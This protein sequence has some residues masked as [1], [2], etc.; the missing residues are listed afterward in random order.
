[1]SRVMKRWMATLAAVALFGTIIAATPSQAAVPG[2][3]ERPKAVP[4]SQLPRDVKLWGAG[5]PVFGH[6]SVWASLNNIPPRSQRWERS[7]EGLYGLKFPWF[8]SP[9]VGDVPTITGRR[10][11]GPGTFSAKAN[12]AFDGT[13]WASSGLQFSA[14]GCWEVTGEYRGEELTFRVHV[15]A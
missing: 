2:G 3:C 15:R 9:A 7:D 11:D 14:P 12:S 6:G 4:R 1:M 5:N 13:T 8:L 10:L